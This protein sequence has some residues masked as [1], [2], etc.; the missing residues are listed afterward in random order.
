MM[1]ILRYDLTE[2]D[3]DK[4]G[5]L[6]GDSFFGSAGFLDL[7]RVIGGHPVVWAILQGDDIFAAMP[8]VEFGRGAVKRFQAMPDG[9]YGRIFFASRNKADNQAIAKLLAHEIAKADYA[10]SY[11]YDFYGTLPEHM[12]F[13]QHR[14]ET[15]IV[16]ISDSKWMPPDKKMQ[17]EIRKAEREVV[18]VVPF[19]R[20]THMD[21]FLALMRR[22][23]RRHG[24]Q[25]KYPGKFFEALAILA[26]QDSRIIWRWCEYD[27]RAVTSHINFLEGDMV[28]NWQVYYDRSFSFLKANQY[29]LYS[30]IQQMPSWSKQRLNLGSTPPDA[31]NL[32]EYKRKWGGRPYAYTCHFRKSGLG[33]LL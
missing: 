16:A 32:A 27:G 1:D 12:E 33:K 14:C 10:K 29:I 21:K 18:S 6:V 2:V 3:R 13:N 7:W 19:D 26:E 30:I 11:I 25:A 15:S 8:G 23:E 24:R 20:Q 28:L 22:A 4:L 17:S 31:E 5:A 9:C